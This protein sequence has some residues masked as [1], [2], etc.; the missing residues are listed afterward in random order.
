MKFSIFLQRRLHWI[1]LPGAILMVLLQR[2]PA[3]NAVV[4]ADEMAAQ[5]PVG[6]ILR[7]VVAAVAALGAVNTM[8]GATPLVPSSGTSSGIT[9]AAGSSVFVSYTVN[10]TQTPPESWSV[11][12]SIPPGLDFSGL[13]DSGGTVNTSFLNLSGTPTIGGTYSVTLQAFEFSDGGGIESPSYRHY[14]ITVTGSTNVAPS[15][16]AQ[17]AS[18]TITA[19]NSVTFSGAASGSPN[20]TYQWQK[21]GGDIGGAT[22]TS[23]TI[24][25]VSPGDAGSYTLVATNA[26]GLRSTTR[27]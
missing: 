14:T 21:N 18:Q 23:Y 10:G 3:L 19:G 12:G 2:M 20:P 16:T 7:S 22:G 11:S 25:S 13:T 5:A 6:V 4:A 27:L 24:P 9:V 8:A 1:N 26:A 15:I 17:P